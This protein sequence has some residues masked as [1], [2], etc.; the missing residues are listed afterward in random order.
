ML[1]KVATAIKKKK[2]TETK[3]WYHSFGNIIAQCCELKPDI[4][5]LQ[6]IC[7]ISSLSWIKIINIDAHQDIDNQ[8]NMIY[9]Y[10][11]D[12]YK[13][14]LYEYMAAVVHLIDDHNDIHHNNITPT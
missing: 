7:W 1:H 5:F 2:K 10:T 3:H 12:V 8:N 9:I 4:A 6:G 13:S 11:Y 14:N